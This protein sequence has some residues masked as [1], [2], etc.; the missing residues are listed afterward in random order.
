MAQSILEL[1]F[2]TAKQGQGGKQAAAELRELKSTVGGVIGGPGLFN[3]GGV[4]AAGAITGI[5]A[6]LRD[7]IDDWSK[8]AEE[9]GRASEAAGISV[10][11][12]SR[13][14][15]AA[16]DARVDVG[17]LQGAFEIA[18]KNGFQPSI[19]N[20]AD[21]ADEIKGISDPTERAARLSK[22]F[23]KSWEDVYAFLKDGG[24]AI[25][26]NTAAIS[27]SMIVTQ[28]AVD[29]NR[30]YIKALDDWGDAWQGLSNTAAQTVLPALTGQAKVLAEDLQLLADGV[31]L[32]EVL[33]HNQSEYA[34]QA[35]LSADGM[36]EWGMRYQGLADLAKQAAPEVVDETEKITTATEGAATAARDLVN[37]FVTLDQIDPSFGSDIKS[38]LDDLAFYMAGGLPLQQMTESIKKAF[39][40]GKISPEMAQDMFAEAFIAEQGFEVKMGKIDAREAAKN[41]Q[42]QLGGSLT[43]AAAKVDVIMGKLD[44]LPRE[45]QIE[46]QYNEV[47]NRRSPQNNG[48]DYDVP[49]GDKQANGGWVTVPP[50]FPNDSYMVGL[51]SGETAHVTNDRMRWMGEAAPAGGV[52]ININGPIEMKGEMDYRTFLARLQSDY[53]NIFK[54]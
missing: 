51:S 8:Y 36:K 54:R 32:W 7:S 34:L 31:P 25:R 43:E 44:S 53:R 22:I 9:M 13:I 47:I 20:L 11:D 30:E 48:P 21:L 27:D 45:I 38:A 17:K 35:A 2:K 49:I 6:G 4:A 39:N 14:T 28:D 29:L 10:E 18:L 42:E 12:M 1:I 24:Q 5:V 52:N 23:G 40:E 16:D 41:I 19:D 50:G 37:Q 46:I 3:Q 26:A 33:K 15:Q